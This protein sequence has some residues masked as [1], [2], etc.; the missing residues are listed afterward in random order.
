MPFVYA[1]YLFGAAGAYLFA[2]FMF[3]LLGATRLLAIPFLLVALA[4][5]ILAP[6]LHVRRF[7]AVQQ[8]A[9][10][11]ILFI[12]RLEGGF[13]TLY[14]GDSFQSTHSYASM[15]FETVHQQWGRYSLIEIMQA[16]GQD[17]YIGFYNDII[18]WDFAPGNG[19]FTH[20]LGMLPLELAPPGG[21]IAIIGAGAGRQVQYARK[22]GHDFEQILAIEIEPAVLDAVRG[23]LADRFD[24]VYEDSQVQLVNREA[25]S[26]MEVWVSNSQLLLQQVHYRILMFAV[27]SP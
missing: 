23:S 14:K 19:F 5:W 2:E 16:P 24:H 15:G 18:Q 12:P 13:L 10:L 3:P 17:G 7:V 21:R 20:S 6:P 4:M 1:I 11:A 22:S 8:I 25:R 27:S 26:Y 9:V